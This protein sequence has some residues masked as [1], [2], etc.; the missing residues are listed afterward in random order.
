[1]TTVEFTTEELQAVWAVLVAQLEKAPH[2]ITKP[3]YSNAQNAR[4][5]I[6]AALIAK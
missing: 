3:V 5:R 2:A 6:E 4:Q 1:M